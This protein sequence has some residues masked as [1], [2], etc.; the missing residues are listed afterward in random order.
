MRV[1]KWGNS[2]AIRHS[3]LYLIPSLGFR[4]LTLVA[5]R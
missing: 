3:N 2:L 5:G 1:L 4:A